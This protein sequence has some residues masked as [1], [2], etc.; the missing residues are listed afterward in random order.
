MRRLGGT[1]ACILLAITAARS[2]LATERVV[3]CGDRTGVCAGV[4]P[5]A[6]LR[7]GAFAG[8]IE[9][10][11]LLQ[12]PSPRP[13]VL[14]LTGSEYQKYTRGLGVKDRERAILHREELVAADPERFVSQ[15]ALASL[16]AAAVSVKDEPLALEAVV[17]AAAEISGPSR[18]RS[19][20][21]EE[22]LSSARE[23]LA[24]VIA[25]ALAPVALAA[26]EREAAIIE[27]LAA[28]LGQAAGLP[29]VDVE[30][31]YF[32]AP[33]TT[34]E[35]ENWRK[36]GVFHHAFRGGVA[37]VLA[38]REVA[39]F[40]RGRRST[41]V[42]PGREPF[43]TE[44]LALTAP[45]M[46]QAIAARLGGVSAREQAEYAVEV[47][48]RHAVLCRLLSK[49][50]FASKVPWLNGWMAA[51]AQDG[52][53][54]RRLLGAT[55]PDQGERAARLEEAQRDLALAQAIAREAGKPRS[56]ANFNRALGVLQTVSVSK[57][58]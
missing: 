26:Y 37:V 28:D 22:L 50:L 5:K 18:F 6:L 19:S 21:A 58:P 23:S 54:L 9:Q 31:V 16:L 3:Y 52:E 24:R 35:V 43:L 25:E 42:Y 13:R 10:E 4:K 27:R 32:V 15:G 12:S 11:T 14:Y 57:A 20:T 41:V 39:S 55:Y 17:G 30:R 38:T 40:A 46:D 2:A 44:L 56:E 34:A 29:H 45:Q 49:A 1:A 36:L 8:T 7:G 51:V 47:A 48:F 33:V 53:A